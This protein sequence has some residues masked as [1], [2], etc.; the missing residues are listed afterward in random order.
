M[1]TGEDIVETKSRRDGRVT[2]AHDSRE[3]EREKKREGAWM[4]RGSRQGSRK[5]PRSMYGRGHRA[6]TA[7]GEA[8]KGMA[9][10]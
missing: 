9:A 2:L 4:I 7:V 10:I 5:L 1:E 8:Q 6:P 3:K